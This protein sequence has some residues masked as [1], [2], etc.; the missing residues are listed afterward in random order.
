MKKF[1]RKYNKMKNQKGFSLVELM[2]VVAIIGI[3]AAIAIPNYQKFQ[4]RSKQT[5]AKSQLSGI[6]ASQ[7]TF[8]GEWSYGSANLKQI[9]YATDGSNSLYNC[10]WATG[11]Q[12]G[13][14][15]DINSVTRL[16]GYRGPLAKDAAEVNQI[17]TFLAFPSSIAT[18]VDQTRTDITAGATPTLCT[19]S[20][21]CQ[22]GANC[23]AGSQAACII[24]IASAAQEGSF[25]VNNANPGTAS[26]I[27]GCAGDIEGPQE[28]QWTMSQAKIITNTKV[29]I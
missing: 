11:Q 25:P 9:G 1:L 14:T 26:F 3:L 28:D 13:G 8:I 15:S 4:A 21:T 12:A 17:S 29:G 7:M 20:T 23:T 16:A 6:Y 2:V 22:G 10:G 19:W 24:Q 27:I 18:S 5:E